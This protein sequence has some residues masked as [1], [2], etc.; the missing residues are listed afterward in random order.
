MPSTGQQQGRQ[1]PISFHGLDGWKQ[2]G[3]SSRS[4]LAPPGSHTSIP[5]VMPV[6]LVGTGKMKFSSLLLSLAR[7]RFDVGITM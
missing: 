2:G 3:N 6:T 5:R 1:S 7:I 4:T